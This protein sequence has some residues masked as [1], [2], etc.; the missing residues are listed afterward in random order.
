VAWAWISAPL[1]GLFAIWIGLS[2]GP[3]IVLLAVAAIAWALL[4]WL[5]FLPSWQKRQPLA[6]TFKPQVDQI[7][8]PPALWTS[9][10]GVRLPMDLGGLNASWPLARF[11]VDTSGIGISSSLGLPIVPSLRFAW[12]DLSR[13]EAVSHRAFR[14]RLKSARASILAFAVSNRDRVLDAAQASGVEVERTPQ[15]SNW[16]SPGD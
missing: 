2:H 14:I 3:W 6:Q 4:V 8:I 9:V 5:V 12:T 13:I 16:W 11:T 15:P 10:G 1:F 7:T